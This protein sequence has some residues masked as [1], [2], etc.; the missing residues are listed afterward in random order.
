MNELPSSIHNV[1]NSIELHKNKKLT[2]LYGPIYM[3]LDDFPPYSDPISE[4]FETQ[5]NPNVQ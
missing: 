1:V 5:I 2:R 3:N 4:I